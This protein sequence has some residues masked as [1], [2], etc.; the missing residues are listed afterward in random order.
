MFYS[1][2]NEK[3]RA[4]FVM[5]NSAAD[6]G[7][8][9]LEI[10]RTIIETG[11]IDVIVSIGPNFFYTVVLPCTLWFFDR[12]KTMG[13]RK[14]QA[15]FIDARHVYRQVDR[16]HREFTPQQVEFL[17]N[18]VRLWRGE[19]VENL[20]GGADMMAE[21]FPSGRYQDV[22]GLCGVATTNQIRA[23]GW[24]LNPG[25]YVEVAEG[26]REEVDFKERLEELQEE[27]ERLN[28]EASQLQS[29]IAQNVAEFLE[30]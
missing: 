14:D 26:E 13:P 11:A 3:G 7:G 30:A 15:L 20:A 17:A 9:E 23:Q 18:I 16:A 4:G 6:K 24:S 1:A 21:K 25:R 10:R 27:L 2:L 5:A 8:S 28:A 29:R 19:A 12:A 22:P